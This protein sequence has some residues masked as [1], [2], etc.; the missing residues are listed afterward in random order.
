MRACAPVKDS[1]FCLHWV[2]Y[3]YNFTKL[4]FPSVPG[5]KHPAGQV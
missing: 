5:G 2:V 3:N 1:K 4:F